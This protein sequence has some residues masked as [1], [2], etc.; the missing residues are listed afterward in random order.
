MF[1]LI[2]AC[3]RDLDQ[4]YSAGYYYDPEIDDCVKFFQ[5][6]FDI[7]EKYDSEEKCLQN[8]DPGKL[9]N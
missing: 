1:L 6:Y 8:R 4:I 5:H 7:N 9:I 2:A 3:F